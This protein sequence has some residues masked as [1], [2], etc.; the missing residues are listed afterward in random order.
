MENTRGIW[1]PGILQQTQQ[2][3]TWRSKNGGKSPTPAVINLIAQYPSI[4]AAQSSPSA[5]TS[6]AYCAV[7]LL[8]FYSDLIT[9]YSLLFLEKVDS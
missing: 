3:Q 2:R 4:F 6:R 1:S 8:S 7:L 5:I 9:R